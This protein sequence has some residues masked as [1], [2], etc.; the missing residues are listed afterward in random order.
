M[1]LPSISYNEV[2]KIV[3]TY[4]QNLSE[5][6]T[7]KVLNID[8]AQGVDLSVLVNSNESISLD[9]DNSFILFEV[10][11]TTNEF[12]NF[13]SNVDSDIMESV[14][15]YTCNIHIY[16]VSAHK[17]SQNLLSK[18]KN[19]AIALE[20]RNSGLYIH[21]FSFPTSIKEFI[22]NTFWPRCDFSISFYTRF[23]TKLN[24]PVEYFDIDNKPDIK[25]IL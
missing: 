22:N 17:L 19:S 7:G 6:S 1:Q 16:G 23:I 15:S 9:L 4:I 10:V 20:L 8:T 13:I 18:F 5:L 12:N 3:G 11:E 24:N 25:I 21:N 14:I 2:V